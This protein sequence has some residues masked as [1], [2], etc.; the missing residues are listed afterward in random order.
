MPTATHR[1]P[2]LAP[3]LKPGDRVRFVS[4]ASTPDRELVARGAALLTGWGLQVEIA[5]HAFDEL[6]YL[7]GTDEDRLADLNDA[8]RDPGVR[9]VFATTGGKGAYRIADGLDFAAVRRDPKPLVGFSD[10]TAL[11]LPLWKEAGLVG[12]HGPFMN[13]WAPYFDAGSIEAFRRALMTTEEIVVRQDAAELS[14]PLTGGHAVTGFLLGGYL[15]AVRGAVGADLESLDGG[16]LLLEVPRGSG[17]GQ[18]DRGLTQLR[19]SGLLAGLLGVA[20]GQI[21]GFEDD[22]INGWGVLDVL[23]DGLTKLGVPILGGLPIG[24]GRNPATVPLGTVATMDPVGGT[25]SVA[26]GVC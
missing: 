5:E 1:A 20:V 26:A 8:F 12:I 24:H 6:G 17:L 16:I 22:L 15:E 19:R 7:A 14:A 21:T 4:P 9:A 13:W 25:L 18:V 2:V 3:R 23:R 11:H 10:I